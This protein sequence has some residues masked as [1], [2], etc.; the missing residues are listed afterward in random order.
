MRGHR[1]SVCLPGSLE[2]GGGGGER[3]GGGGFG[4]RGAPRCGGRCEHGRREE[5]CG[6]RGGR[7]GGRGPQQRPGQHR[8]REGGRAQLRVQVQL[9]GLSLATNT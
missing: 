1:W 4:R 8:H 3:G 7:G 2:L 5:G 6:G 9:H